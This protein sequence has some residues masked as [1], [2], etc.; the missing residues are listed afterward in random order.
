MSSETLTTAS[1]GHKAGDIV[2]RIPETTAER[3]RDFIGMIGLQDT[4]QTCQGQNLK[5]A[6]PNEEC[7]KI[8]LRHAMDL[9]DGGPEDLLA[10]AQA[11]IPVEPGVNK[12]IDFPIPSISIGGSVVFVQLYWQMFSAIAQAPQVD[13]NWDASAP[14]RAHLVLQSL[15]TQPCLLVKPYQRYFSVRATF[16]RH[17]EGRP[18]VC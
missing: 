18:S 3:I 11:N 6:D 1:S 12:P 7:I 13:Q 15:R 14:P 2:Y 4:Q 9:A 5:R 17:Q 10:L 8:I 16:Q